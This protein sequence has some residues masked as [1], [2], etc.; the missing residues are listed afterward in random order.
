MK[1]ATQPRDDQH[2]RY[3]PRS[4]LLILKSGLPRLLVEVNSTQTP[5]WPP[6][7]TRMLLQGTAM[8]CFAKFLDVGEFVLVG[9]FIRP[10]GKATRL[11]Q[12]NDEAVCSV[13]YKNRFVS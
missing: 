3:E 8:I 12:G 9:F 11:F 1:C 6:D 4:D 10:D 13:S 5:E 7:P 2:R